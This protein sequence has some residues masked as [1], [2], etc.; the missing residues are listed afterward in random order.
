MHH[1]SRITVEPARLLLVEPHADTRDTF[2]RLLRYLGYRVTTAAGARDAVRLCMEFDFDLM[3][4]EPRL[5]DGDGAD[6]AHRLLAR[7]GL[8]AMAVSAAAYPADIAAGLDA[9]FRVY[10][11][12]PL[13]LERF[14]AGIH[15]ALGLT[16]A[17]TPRHAA[18]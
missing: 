5:P 10:L 1:E 12:K 11:T 7:H 3:V 14:A 15:Q 4:C 18:S 2:A 16:P 9:G 17:P 6:L 8:P 13:P